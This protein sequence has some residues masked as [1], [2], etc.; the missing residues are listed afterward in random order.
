MKKI[1][2]TLIISSFSLGITFAQKGKIT[3]GVDY[4]TSASQQ[5]YAYDLYYPYGYNS[6]TYKFEP[7]VG[8]FIYDNIEIGFG[9]KAGDN[10]DER[11]FISYNQF[12]GDNYEYENTSNFDYKVF[13]PYVKYYLN[14]LFFSARF[15]LE[16]RNDNQLNNY[17][18]WEV[19]TN[20]VNNVVGMDHYNYST[21]ILRK[22]TVFSIGY[23]LA[24]N[25]KLFFEPSIS[26]RKDFGEV[27][28]KS[29]NDFLIGEDINT[30]STSPINNATHF[31]LN[32]AVGL[33]LGK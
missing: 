7:R 5:I 17:P 21:Q 8:Y 28:N 14:N 27:N 2:L 20:G 24:Y 15:S 29:D 30:E 12:G 13:S 3:L 22:S 11:T 9:F 26:I 6:Q 23:V 16:K 32:I 19:D 31:S 18:I 33:R 10:E 1:L 4:S 25:E